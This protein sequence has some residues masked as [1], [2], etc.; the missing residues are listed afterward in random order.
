MACAHHHLQAASVR[1]RIAIMPGRAYSKMLT[2]LGRRQPSRTA[3]LSLLSG[4]AASRAALR[5]VK[6]LVSGLV[7]L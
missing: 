4:Y 2:T 6:N 3:S 1:L 5:D 7:R